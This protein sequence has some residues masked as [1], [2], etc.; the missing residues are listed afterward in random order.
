[1]LRDKICSPD[2]A[3]PP[4]HDSGG[5]NAG[6]GTWRAADG[7]YSIGSKRGIRL[8][9]ERVPVTSMTQEMAPKS[10][11]RAMLEGGPANLPHESRNLLIGAAEEM[12]KV[13]H[14]GGYE[15][16]KRSTESDTDEPLVFRWSARTEIAE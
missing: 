5:E 14:Y 3:P 13:S 6:P 1:V 15:H 11:V 9:I 2:A 16:F 7:Y 8:R 4:I 12:I 10:F